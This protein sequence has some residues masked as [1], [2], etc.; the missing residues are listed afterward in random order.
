MK[1]GALLFRVELDG[2]VVRPHPNLPPLRRE[3]GALPSFQRKLESRMLSTDESWLTQPIWIL[4]YARMTVGRIFLKA[5]NY[6]SYSAVR[7]PSIT[8]SEPVTKDA[9]SE[10]RYRAP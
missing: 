6:T 8:N 10:A 4:A 2:E 7:P 1:D 5:E 9:S 3:K